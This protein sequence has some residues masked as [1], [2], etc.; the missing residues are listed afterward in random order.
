MVIEIIFTDF[1]TI[2]SHTIKSLEFDPS[3]VDAIPV[4]TEYTNRE[5]GCDEHF[6]F[7][8]LSERKDSNLAICEIQ[9]ASISKL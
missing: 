8:L 5:F 6:L 7:H 3:P 1:V 9:S 4:L 2:E